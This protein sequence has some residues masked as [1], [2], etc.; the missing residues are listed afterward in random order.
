MLRFF[1]FNTY[2]INFFK[3][4]FLI[5]FFYKQK[6]FYSIFYF[7]NL[8][9]IFFGEKY[10]IEYQTKNIFFY[11]NNFLF[12]HYNTYNNNNIT[13]IYYFLL[14]FCIYLNIFILFLSI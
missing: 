3:K 14:S 6:C 10:L 2:Y 4:N 8:S 1:F 9:V 12:K 5:D 13:L 7:L 11:F